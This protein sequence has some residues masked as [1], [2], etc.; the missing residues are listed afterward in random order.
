MRGVS[1]R[2]FLDPMSVDLGNAPTLLVQT[3]SVADY[4]TSLFLG[5]AGANPNVIFRKAS[6]RMAA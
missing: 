6:Y 2:Y 3:V 5:K 1:K 4:G